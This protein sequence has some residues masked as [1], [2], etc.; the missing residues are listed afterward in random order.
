MRL[1][2]D[3]QALSLQVFDDGLTSFIT[4]HAAV[5]FGHVVIQ[6]SRLGHN[7]DL[8]EVVAFADFKVVEVV[9]RRNLHAAGA[10]LFIHIIVCNDRN[11]TVG[12]RQFQFLADQAFVAFVFGIDRYCLVTEHGFRTGRCN[13]DTFGAVSSRVTDFPEMSVH[14]L[15]FHLEVGNRGLKFRVPVHKTAASVDQAFFVQV[16]KAVNHD[17]GEVVI[18]CEIE[19]VPVKGIAQTAHLIKDV[20]AGVVLPLPDFFDEF[21]ARHIAA[22]LALSFQLTFNNDLS[23]DTGVVGSRQPHRVVAVHA[24]EAGQGVHHTVVEGVTHMKDTGNVRRRQLDRERGLAFCK[25]GLEITLF[26]PEGIPLGF[27]RSRIVTLSEFFVLCFAH[28]A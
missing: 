27:N 7:I 19:A 18:H 17:L 6:M 22:I 26:F 13:N 3:E 8:F 23:C 5:L 12:Q 1:D 10:E 16:D 9:G 2:T 11:F 15:R 25:A 4:I 21:V 28:G 24:V 14:F 20:A